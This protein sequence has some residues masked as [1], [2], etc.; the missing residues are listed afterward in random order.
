MG[1]AAIYYYPEESAP[2]TVIDLGESLSDMQVEPVRM[3][4]T[5][6]GMDLEPSTVD[7][8]GSHR[9][10][11]V[12]ERFTGAALVA[13]LRSF[14]SHALR[15]LPFGVVAD[16]DD[17]WAGFVA[18]DTLRRG[19]TTVTTGG[20]M[21]SSWSGVGSL[22]ADDVVVIH[23]MN[24]EYKHEQKIVSTYSATTGIVSFGSTRVLYKYDVGPIVV[25]H[26]DFF[27][28]CYLDPS[29]RGSILTHDHRITWTLDLPC[30]Y[31][32]SGMQA[33]YTD[34]GGD[35]L[36]IGST[37]IGDY[38]EGTLQGV[39]FG[40]ETLGFGGVRTRKTRI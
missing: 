27:P 28:V 40:A 4:D 21:F 11:V 35:G 36:L 38:P 23:S 13:S 18:G 12:L 5:A 24:P 25:R 2:L 3:V 9:V 34:D 19:G 26:R 14:E 7:L 39:I 29:N 10:R 16:T 8:G 37:G 33:L 20:T 30:L 31:S 6:T 17:S 32:P 15:G 22:Q 1:N